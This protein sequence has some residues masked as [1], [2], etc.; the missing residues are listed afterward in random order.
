[1]TETVLQSEGA[2]RTTPATLFGWYAIFLLAGFILT[3]AGFFVLIRLITAE[4]GFTIPGLTSATGPSR[5]L[6]ICGALTSVVSSVLFLMII[7]RCWRALSPYAPATRPG[8]YIAL[9][10][11]PVVN[12]IWAFKAIA[13][14]PLAFNRLQG[15]IPE[16]K[17]T[18][19][20]TGFVVC[21]LPLLPVLFLGAMVISPSV[22]MLKYGP[23]VLGA[24]ATFL[25]FSFTAGITGG[26]AAV[27]EFNWTE[28]AHAGHASG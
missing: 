26:L 20:L 5:I 14:V 4:D 17:R 10:L 21:V 1:M 24:A 2:P 11:I 25:H 12:F 7:Y 19:I 13:G 9:L 6:S 23:I 22:E 15:R 28:G 27:E 16:L 3:A 8:L 18:P